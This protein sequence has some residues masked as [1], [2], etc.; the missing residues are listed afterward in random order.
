MIIYKDVFT[1]D[2]IVSDC[3]PIQSY[4]SAVLEIEGKMALECSDLIDP[5]QGLGSPTDQYQET[6]LHV[7]N[8]VASFNLQ[9]TPFDKK[10][11][12]TFIKDYIARLQQYLEQYNPERV[13]SFLKDSQE[14]ARDIISRFDE[15]VFF[16]G[17]SADPRGGLVMMYYK[18]DGIV[19]FF[20]CFA[21][22]L[23]AIKI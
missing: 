17:E 19:P 15:F 5:T 10:G 1:G 11:F 18:N 20:L 3:Y 8:L 12:I 7:I 14:A 16:T 23:Q 13:L 4:N 22:G 9:E 21:D 2:E 6:V